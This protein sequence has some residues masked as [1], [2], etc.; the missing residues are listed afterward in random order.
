MHGRELTA[1]E[2]KLTI[3]TMTRFAIIIA[4]VMSVS[5]LA[6]ASAQTTDNEEKLKAQAAGYFLTYKLHGNI[7]MLGIVRM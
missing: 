4:S 1:H 5:A 2:N 3:T 6:T 7:C